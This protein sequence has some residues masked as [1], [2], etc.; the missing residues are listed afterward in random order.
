MLKIAVRSHDQSRTAWTLFPI[1][2]RLEIAPGLHMHSSHNSEFSEQQMRRLSRYTI[3]VLDVHSS[4]NRGSE[5]VI[6]HK[7]MYPR[8]P[9]NIND[10]YFG[11]DSEAC[12]LDR[13]GPTDMTKALFWY[14]AQA[15][16]K[17]FGVQEDYTSS[18]ARAMSKTTSARTRLVEQSEIHTRKL[19][20]N[21]DPYSSAYARSTVND[22]LACLANMQLSLRGSINHNDGRGI[23]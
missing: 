10:S 11:P 21:C 3:C 7:S 2:I 22:S 9:F 4:F 1:A 6:A 14:H 5:P 17:V 18:S 15:T 23:L 19:L 20:Q 12:F 8:L 16:G 13:E